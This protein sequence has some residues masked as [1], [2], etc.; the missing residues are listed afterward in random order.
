MPYSKFLIV[1][2]KLDKAGINIT[3]QLS[4]FGNFKFYLVDKEIIYTENLGLEKINQYDFIIF[5]SRHQSEKKEKTLS[6]HAPGNWRLAEFVGEKGKACRSSALF[7][8]QMFEKLN[9][10]AT[11]FSLN[12]YKVTMETTHHGPLIDKP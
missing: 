12:D 4:Q 3:T 11:K 10:N 5:A 8:K 9:E 6:V 2:S 7:S 1:A